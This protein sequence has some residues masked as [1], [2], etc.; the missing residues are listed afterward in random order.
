MIEL[1]RQ[2]NNRFQRTALRPAAEP[3]RW[4]DTNL[5]YAAAWTPDRTGVMLTTT[6]RALAA[7]PVRLLA[8]V[9]LGYRTGVQYAAPTSPTV[10]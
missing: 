1:K 2:S 5:A 7:V 10:L 3:E 8:G 9:F 6:I 4:A